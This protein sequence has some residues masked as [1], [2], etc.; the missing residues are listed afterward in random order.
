MLAPLSA[1]D[2][3]RYIRH[4]RVFH[5]ALVRVRR[6][7]GSSMPWG[8]DM[9]EVAGSFHVEGRLSNTVKAKV[10]LDL[11]MASLA[12]RVVAIRSG[13]EPETLDTIPV[14][15]VPVGHRGDPYSS[16]AY[17]ARRIHGSVTFYSVGPDGRDH[18]GD[19]ARDLVR[20]A[21]D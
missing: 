10:A 12:S 20:P 8:R 17:R 4:M 9:D 13:R 2:E 7:C 1:L 19:P 5:E 16:Q 14:A 3:A 21:H 11:S 6:R 18:D 15:L